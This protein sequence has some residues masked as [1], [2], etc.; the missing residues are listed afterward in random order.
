MDYQKYNRLV[1]R[2]TQ[3]AHKLKDLG[4]N[5]EFRIAITNRLLDKLYS[6]GVISNKNGSLQEIEEKLCVSSFCRR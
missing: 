6:K 4:A 2:V 1:G 3:L 5:D